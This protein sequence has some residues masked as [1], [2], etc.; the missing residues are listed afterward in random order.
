MISTANVLK[1]EGI[2]EQND[3]LETNFWKNYVNK[4]L[5]REM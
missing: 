1:I 2:R 4:M 5:D 3:I